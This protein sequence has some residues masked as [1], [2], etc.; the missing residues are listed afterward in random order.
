[1]NVVGRPWVWWLLGGLL[2]LAVG[3]YVGIV[4]GAG[5]AWLAFD[6]GMAGGAMLVFAWMDWSYRRHHH[7]R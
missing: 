5:W 4:Y 1:V 3:Q 7:D 2:V 6:T